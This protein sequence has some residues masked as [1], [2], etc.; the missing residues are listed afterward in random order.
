MTPPERSLYGEIARQ[1]AAKANEESSYEKRAFKALE[2]IK[3]SGVPDKDREYLG[4]L[5]RF[6]IKKEVSETD[7]DDEGNENEEIRPKETRPVRTRRPETKTS[8]SL[9]NLPIGFLRRETEIPEQESKPT[10][11]RRPETGSKEPLNLPKDFLRRP[12]Q[13]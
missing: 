11:S 12:P 7:E 8:N 5:V 1:I 3:T 13:K 6:H 4:G 2:L 9:S 10:G